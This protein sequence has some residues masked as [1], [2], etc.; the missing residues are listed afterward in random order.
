MADCAEDSGCST[1]H[2]SA[3]D[4]FPGGAFRPVAPQLNLRTFAITPVQATH[5]RIVVVASQCTGC[6]L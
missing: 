2:T 5:L 3:P 6:P 4:A 1:V